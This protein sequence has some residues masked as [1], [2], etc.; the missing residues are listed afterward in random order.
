MSSIV[1]I[2]P[3]VFKMDEVTVIEND[4]HPDDDSIDETSIE[5][6]AETPWILERQDSTR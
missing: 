5:E 6:K 4:I 3:V 1:G 2:H